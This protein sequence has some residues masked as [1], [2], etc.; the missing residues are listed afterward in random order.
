MLAKERLQLII[1]K[2]AEADDDNVDNDDEHKAFMLVTL[3]VLTNK[4]FIN[5]MLYW[6]VYKYHPIRRPK[7][8][9]GMGELQILVHF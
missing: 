9:L 4:L 2:I 1:I 3:I 5:V 8:Q 7:C 6:V